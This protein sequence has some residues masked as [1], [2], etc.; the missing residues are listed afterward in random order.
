MINKIKCFFNFHKW[1]R[2]GELNVPLNQA[3]HISC[4]HECEYCKKQEFKGMG[5]F[6]T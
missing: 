6:L 4:L 1:K 3:T 5:T 2:I